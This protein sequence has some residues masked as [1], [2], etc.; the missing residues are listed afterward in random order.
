MDTE[1]V[2]PGEEGDEL[3]LQQILYTLEGLRKDRVRL[4]QQREKDRDNLSELSRQVAVNNQRLSDVLDKIEDR[5]DTAD[6]HDDAITDLQK[7]VNMGAGGIIV[8]QFIFIIL[9]ENGA[10]G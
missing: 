8:A 2:T 6:K 3:L 9:I 4:D 10:F 5:E 7:Q 1:G